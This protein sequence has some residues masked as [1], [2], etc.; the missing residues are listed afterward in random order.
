MD[1]ASQWAPPHSANNKR[2]LPD[3][4]RINREEEARRKKK[5]K[6]IEAGRVKIESKYKWHCP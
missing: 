1:Q 5:N 3:Y 2:A 4:Q 6:S